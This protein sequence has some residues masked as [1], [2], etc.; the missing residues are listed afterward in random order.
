MP[1]GLSGTWD[2]GQESCVPVSDPGLLRLTS[3]QRQRF[4]LCLIRAPS[5]PD[6]TRPTDPAS[7]PSALHTQATAPFELGGGG[8][9]TSTGLLFLRPCIPPCAVHSSMPGSEQT[10]RGTQC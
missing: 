6:F 1:R 10:T 3:G 5:G 9:L 4:S 8:S 2:E 7:V